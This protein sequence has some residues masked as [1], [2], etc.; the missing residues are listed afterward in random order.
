[1]WI[2]N[3]GPNTFYPIVFNI[4]NGTKSLNVM[5]NGSEAINMNNVASCH[6]SVSSYVSQP[7]YNPTLNSQPSNVFG[8]AKGGI[9]FITLSLPCSLGWRTAGTSYFLVV[10]GRFGNSMAFSQFG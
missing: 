4:Y 6:P 10:T 1:M 5:W 7:I 2:Y 9:A 3:S 8:I